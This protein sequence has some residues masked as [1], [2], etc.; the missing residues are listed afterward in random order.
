MSDSVSGKM[1]VFTSRLL[2]GLIGPTVQPDLLTKC[3]YQNAKTL[4]HAS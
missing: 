4:H 3:E 2:R 1:H